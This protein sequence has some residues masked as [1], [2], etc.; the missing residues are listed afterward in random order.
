MRKIKRLVTLILLLALSA[1]SLLFSEVNLYCNRNDT[2]TVTLDKTD[3][4]YIYQ[5]KKKF[6]DN[7]SRIS[8][9]MLPYKNYGQKEFIINKLGLSPN[10][11]KR[12][13]DKNKNIIRV[14][15]YKIFNKVLKHK[16]SIGFI[17]DD[18]VIFNIDDMLIKIKIEG[19]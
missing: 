14:N 17:N 6:W 8:V 16:G 1:G 11:F 5:G 19:D 13:T 4:I 2:D 9:Y 12:I 3:V 15:Q 7:G 18:T 10:K